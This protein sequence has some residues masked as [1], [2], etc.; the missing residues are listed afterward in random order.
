MASA[1]EIQRFA[2]PCCRHRTLDA[3]GDYDIC[4]VCLWEDDGQ[5]DHNAHA[6]SGGPNGVLSLT[7]ARA[8]FARIGACEARFVGNVRAPR[9]EESPWPN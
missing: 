9:P 7:Q 6:V 3:R 8:N 4:P 5:D 1:G 2:C